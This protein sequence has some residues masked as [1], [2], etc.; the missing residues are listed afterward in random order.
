MGNKT[1]LV[2]KEVVADLFAVFSFNANPGTVGKS[3]V[4]PK[5]P[6]NLILPFVVAS[7]SAIVAAATCE[8]T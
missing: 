2:P 4:P 3:A 7:A 1:S 5:S 8:S 6:A